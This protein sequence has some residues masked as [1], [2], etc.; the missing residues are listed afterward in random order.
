MSIVPG[1]NLMDRS[2]SI[3]APSLLDDRGVVQISMSERELDLREIPPPERHSTIFEAVEDLESGEALAIINDHEPTP[4]Y[5]QMAA[6][7]DAFDAESYTV[8]RV[9]PRSFSETCSGLSS[10]TVHIP[11]ETS[12]A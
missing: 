8:V 3:F 12:L 1:C 10:C 4:L 5:H 9:G 7:V 2:A 6:E 11:S